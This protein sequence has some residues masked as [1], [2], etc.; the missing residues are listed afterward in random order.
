MF[1]SDLGHGRHRWDAQ[2]DAA[3]G[4]TKL[5]TATG[6]GRLMGAPC[7]NDDVPAAFE[8][9]SA[10]RPAHG[11]CTED[12]ITHAPSFPDGGTTQVSIM[13]VTG[14]SFASS[15][16]ISAPKLPVATLAPR[17]RSCSTTLST[18]GSATAPG[19]AAAYDGLRP[20]A[21]SA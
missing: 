9:P 2:R 1:E 6:D 13:S 18:R 11:P 10:D 14:P 5:E 4:V 8:K 7:D 21:V 19:P 12:D 20:L 16:S 17:L 15:T 3:I